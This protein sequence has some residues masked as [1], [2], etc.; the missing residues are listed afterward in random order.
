M[1]SLSVRDTLPIAVT[2]TYRSRDAEVRPFGAGTTYPYTMFLWSAQQYTEADLV[3]PDGAKIHYVRTSGGV[4]ARRHRF[5]ALE[6]D[7]HIAASSRSPGARAAPARYSDPPRPSQA[8]SRSVAEIVESERCD[9]GALEQPRPRLARFRQRF[10][11]NPARTSIVKW[12]ITGRSGGDPSG[13][14]YRAFQVRKR[15]EAS[16]P[17]RAADGPR[18]WCAGAAARFGDLVGNFAEPVRR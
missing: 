12:D 7:A 6:P 9:L 16:L 18:H 14:R 8:C 17:T 3:L 11:N 15:H 5:C 13:L 4:S 2:R 1:A 10:R